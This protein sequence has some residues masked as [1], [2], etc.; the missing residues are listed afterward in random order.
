MAVR[1]GSPFLILY[2]P[3]FL[4][5]YEHVEISKKFTIS[6]SL[7]TKVFENPCIYVC[8][9]NKGLTEK[10]LFFYNDGTIFMDLCSIQKNGRH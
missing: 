9:V 4:N 7:V 5:G 6:H 2:H 10:S 3:S 8:E 1:S